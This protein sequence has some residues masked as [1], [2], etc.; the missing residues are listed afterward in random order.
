MM[1][2]RLNLLSPYKKQRLTQLVH[3]LFIKELLE[4]TILAASLMAIVHLT[5]WYLLTQHLDILAQSTTIVSRDFS[6]PHQT[7]VKMNSLIKALQR[8]GD[9]FAPLSPYLVELSMTLPA[10]IRLTMINFDR[11]EQRLTIAGLAKTRAALL[12]F[13][14]ALHQLS[15]LGTV[16]T[17]TS[18][19]LQKDNIPF[20]IKAQLQPAP[21]VKPVSLTGSL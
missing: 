21:A 7:V 8:A 17:P 18:Q 9:G 12:S 19:L 6:R 4:L 13:Q 15:W 10:D 1:Q 5:G 16:S 14:A 2:S 3:F 11:S 20:E